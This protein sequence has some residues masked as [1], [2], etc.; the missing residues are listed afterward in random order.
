M[1]ELNDIL[2]EMKI[3]LKVRQLHELYLYASFNKNDMKMQPKQRV[4]ALINNQKRR[5]DVSIVAKW[6][7]ENIKKGSIKFNRNR[8][9]S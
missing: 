5:V 6:L 9:T 8:A 4:A 2:I 1:N 7:N 3:P